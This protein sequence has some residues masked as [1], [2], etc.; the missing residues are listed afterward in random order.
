MSEHY[1]YVMVGAG[2][3][4]CVLASR[5][6]E[7]PS[8]RVL[9]LEAGGE[10]WNPLVHIPIGTGKLLRRGGL[11]GWKLF[12]EYDQALAGRREFWPRGRVIGG[13]SSIN[14][15]Q[16]LSGHLADYDHWRDLGNPR[17]GLYRCP[18]RIS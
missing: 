5:L 1:T 18:F 16:Y 15:M 2:S 3:A 9:L 6:L 13:S 4:G 7:Y 14:G 8:N 10:D 12:A 11:H 17:Q